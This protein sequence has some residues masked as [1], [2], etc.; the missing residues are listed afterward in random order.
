MKIMIDVSA[1]QCF[2]MG[3]AGIMVNTRLTLLLNLNTWMGIFE[4]F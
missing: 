3:W 4:L 2:A 1:M